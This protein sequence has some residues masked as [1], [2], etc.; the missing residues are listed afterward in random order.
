MP[1]VLIAIVIA[2]SLLA[3]TKYYPLARLVPLLPIFT[4]IAHYIAGSKRTRI[5]LKRTMLF[6][7]YSMVPLFIYLMALYALIDLMPLKLALIC[8][9]ALWCLPATLLLI[10][11]MKFRADAAAAV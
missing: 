10:L 6:S 11:W 2:L 9:S 4:L 5:E 8:A 1:G 7:L 3:L